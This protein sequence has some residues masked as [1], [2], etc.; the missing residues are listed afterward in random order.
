MRNQRRLRLY[1]RLVSQH[2]HVAKATQDSFASFRPFNQPPSL[3]LL[4]DLAC[5]AVDF[6]STPLQREMN[7]EI[8][9]A[10][11]EDGKLGVEFWLVGTV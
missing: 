8:P 5:P 9:V 11:W 4:N 6:E 10:A 7:D 2:A 1:D 3:N